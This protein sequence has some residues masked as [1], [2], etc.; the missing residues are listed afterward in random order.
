LLLLV[1]IDLEQQGQRADLTIVKPTAAVDQRRWGARAGAPSSDAGDHALRLDQFAHELN[2]LLDGSLRCLSLAEQAIDRGA[3]SNPVELQSVLGKLGLA[4]QSMR[5]MARLLE[6]A[7][8]T[9]GVGPH[10]FIDRTPIGEAVRSIIAALRPQAAQHQIELSHFIESSAADLP[11]GPL[12]PVI[13]NGLRNALHAVAN[14]TPAAGCVRKVDCTISLAAPDAL[15]LRIIDNGPGLAPQAGLRRGAGSGHGLGLPLCRQIVA[16]LGGTL[17]L[18]NRAAGAK[19]DPSAS[20]PGAALTVI[21][22]TAALTG[23]GP[24]AVDGK[25]S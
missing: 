8:R 15:C 10:T 4:R 9:G 14:I 3:G 11:I 1:N 25:Q 23:S 18:S 12:T 7:M 17:A 13:T 2:T 21:I 24:F 19:D 22:P 6:R 16:S 5:Q 20:S